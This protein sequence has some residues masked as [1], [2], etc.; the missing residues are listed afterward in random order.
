MN[1]ICDIG[2]KSIDVK[3]THPNKKKNPIVLTFDSDDKSIPV[4][5][6]QADNHLNKLE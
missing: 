4:K 5:L 2:D 3:L 6:E 1:V